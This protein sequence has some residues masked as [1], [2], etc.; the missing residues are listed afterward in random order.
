MRKVETDKG[1][2][3]LSYLIDTG[4]DER[5]DVYT[6]DLRDEAMAQEFDKLVAKGAEPHKAAAKVHDMDLPAMEVVEDVVR[7]PQQIDVLPVD[8]QPI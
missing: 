1:E 3:V 4:R 6:R 5:V 7:Q 8:V 2:Q